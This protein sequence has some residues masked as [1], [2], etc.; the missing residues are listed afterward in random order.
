MSLV[1]HNR[2]LQKIFSTFFLQN[3]KTVRII[4]QGTAENIYGRK[5]LL[6]WVSSQSVCFLSRGSKVEGSKMSAIY[7]L[8]VSVYVLH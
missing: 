6:F 2:G 5:F 3:C 1:G 7:L 4:V 8:T